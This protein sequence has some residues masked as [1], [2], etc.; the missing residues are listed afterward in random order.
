[1]YNSTSALHSSA[2]R[3]FTQDGITNVLTAMHND[4]IKWIHF[5]RY[6]P[7][8]VEIHR[9]IPLKRPVTR[10]FDVF[11]DLRLNKWLSK[12]SRRWGFE[13]PSRSLWRHSNGGNDNHQEQGGTNQNSTTNKLRLVQHFDF[14][15]Q[16]YKDYG[17]NRQTWHKLAYLIWRVQ[18]SWHQASVR[19]PATV[20][21]TC[22]Q[23]LPRLGS[24]NLYSARVVT[25]KRWSQTGY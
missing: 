1:M 3:T 2:V 16:I 23:L 11:F 6:W 13:T 14:Q 10:S 20:I 8:V 18:M 25:V 15:L 19:S 17:E 21:L 9:W 4:V 12:Q 24:Q 7:F 22:M 5:P